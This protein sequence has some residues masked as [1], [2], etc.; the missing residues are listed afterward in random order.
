MSG[1]NR[2]LSALHPGLQPLVTRWIN[3]CR[4]RKIQ[5]L[6]VET[7]RSWDVMK[8][9]YSRG[10]NELATVNSLY[11][12]AGLRPITL[13]DNRSTITNA[14][15]GESWHYYGLALDA[16][17][18]INGKADWLYNPEDPKDYF[19]E[20]AEEADM[21]G[22]TWGG[23]FRT[24]PDYPHLEYHPGYSASIKSNG[25]KVAYSFSVKLGHLNIPLKGV[26]GD[27]K[28]KFPV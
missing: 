17:P 10:R 23:K 18:V 11:K 5:I 16:V 2:D 3:N 28:V 20:M 26:Y 15:P 9:Y 27:K 25:V 4:A 21:L 1:Q 22:L 19:D 6:V 12:R 24:F 14:M 13:K 8:A 7:A